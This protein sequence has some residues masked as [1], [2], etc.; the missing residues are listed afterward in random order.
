M[1]IVYIVETDFSRIDA[2][3]VRVLGCSKALNFNKSENRIDIIGFSNIK[4]IKIQDF[5]I[6]NVRR[7][8]NFL[9]KIFNNFTRPWQFLSMLK[10]LEKP[11]VVIYYTIYGNSSKTISLLHK[12]CKENKIRFYL[13]VTEVYEIKNLFLGKYG[14]IGRDFVK[15]INDKIFL[16]DGI[17]AI[18]SYIE[19]LFKDKLKVIRIPQIVDTTI[20][21]DDNTIINN[22]DKTYLNLVFAGTYHKKEALETVAD[23]VDDLY[24]KGYKVKLSIIGETKMNFE[25]KTNK[26]FS[27]GIV[28]FGRIPQNNVFKYI[29]N[30][31]FSIV[32]RPIATNTMA[33]FPTKFV[34]SLNAGT[35]VI[36]NLT[37]D[38][39]LYLK[40]DFNG[41]VVKDDSKEEIRKRI[42][43][44]LELPK[45]KIEEMKLNAKKTA[46]ENF[47]YRGYS[48][49]IQSFIK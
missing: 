17:I 15:T 16:S 28:F 12:Y 19:N 13:D 30:A 45:S 9:T 47:D 29:A 8:Y 39:G 2:S 32:I 42:I 33:G 6:Y 34:E 1:K 37:S 4:N 36:A 5:N 46:I 35:P 20:S 3:A 41:F 23:V 25:K 27:E 49:K 11:D 18:S 40:N 48:N 10:T 14:L 31:D 44:I 24:R 43:S 7:G 38:L 21:V 22:N 26:K